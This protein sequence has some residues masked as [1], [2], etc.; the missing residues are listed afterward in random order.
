MN[1]VKLRK[2]EDLSI[3]LSPLS[4]DPHLLCHVLVVFSFPL[5]QR[6]VSSLTQQH[7]SPRPRCHWLRSRSWKKNENAS[8]VKR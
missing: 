6:G 3:V 4:P 5:R 8:F 7:V 1:I 2:V